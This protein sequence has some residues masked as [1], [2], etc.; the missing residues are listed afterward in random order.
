MNPDLARLQAYPFERIRT[1]LQG[2]SPADLPAVSLAMA[3][4]STQPLLSF[5]K[6]LRQIWVV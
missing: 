4:P 5:M 2:I 1:L 6:R 3:E